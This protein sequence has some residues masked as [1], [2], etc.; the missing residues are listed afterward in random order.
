METNNW[1]MQ[2]IHLSCQTNM[3]TEEM[4]EINAN[5]MLRFSLHL[6]KPFIESQYYSTNTICG[7]QIKFEPHST[8][9]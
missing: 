6:Y 4:V 9:D 7:F 2:E 3:Q 8:Q 1:F 5:A